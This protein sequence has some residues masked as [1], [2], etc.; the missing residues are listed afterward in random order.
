MSM[1][2]QPFKKYATF[3][4]RA[5]RSELW[6]FIL[7]YFIVYLV[8]FALGGAV[9]GGDPGKA[10]ALPAIVGLVFFI[11][12]IAVE[13]RR[14]H[15]IDKSGWWLLISLVPLLGAI[16]LLVWFCKSGTAGPNRFGDDP[17]GASAEVL[18]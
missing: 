7:L 8:A 17:K 14:L 9:A 15:D 5:R 2:F 3:T 4:G 16:L 12:M 13:V 18:A 6:M 11:P 1:M 10:M